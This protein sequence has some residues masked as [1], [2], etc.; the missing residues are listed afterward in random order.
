VR[1]SRLLHWKSDRVGLIR[2]YK[3][4]KKALSNIEIVTLA[5]YLLGGDSEYMDTE[6][7]AFKTNELAPRRF[8]WQKYPDQINIEKVRTSL[9]DAKKPKNG[10]YLFGLHSEGWILTENGLKFA[11]MRVKDLESIDISRS[12]LNKKEIAWKNREKSR[13]LATIA[14]EKVDSQNVNS[15]TVQDAENFF[16]LDDYVIGRARERKIARIIAAFSDDPDLS[17]VIKTLAAKVR[18]N[19]GNNRE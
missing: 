1:K 4:M 12:P 5:V 9:S 14:Y 6:D 15:V 2:G 7:I 3:K 10:G 11:K 17:Q 19:V 18:K 8:A 13:M 16:R